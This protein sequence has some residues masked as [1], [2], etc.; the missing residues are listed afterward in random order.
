MPLVY[1]AAAWAAGIAVAQKISFPIH[2]WAWWLIFPLAALILTRFNFRFRLA[3]F[4]LAAFLLGALRYASALPALD[5]HSLA[6]FNDRGARALRG[7]IAD[8]PDIRDT[9]TNLRVAITRARDSSA[10]REIAGVALVQ[11]PRETDARYGDAVE[12]FG[13]PTTP[14]EF[15]D[16]SYKEYLARQGVHSLVRY[17]RVTITAREQG[18]P[19]FAALYAFR[20]RAFVTIRALFPEPAASLLAGILLGLDN[21]IPRDLRDAFSATN[22]AHIVA[23]SGFNIAIIAGILTQLARRAMRPALATLAVIGGLAAYT[24]LVGASASV[25]RAALMGALVVIAAYYNRQ[26][27]A[28]NALAVAALAMTALNPF[29]LFDLGFQLSFLATM[30]LVLYTEPIERGLENVISRI[31]PK[32]DKGQVTRDEG[33]MAGEKEILVTRH[34]S[35]VTL[36][37]DS[38]ITTLAAQITTM[39]LIIFAFHRLSLIGLVTNLLVLPAQPA[40]MIL[41]GLAT[42]VGMIAPPLGQI[43]AWIAWAFLQWTIIV[44][45]ATARVPFASLPVGY[46]DAALVGLYYFA[47]FIA[48]RVDWRALREKI[49]L[50]PA[51]ALGIALVFGIWVFTFASTAPDGK[52]HIYFLDTQGGAAT[53]IRAANGAKILIDGGENPSATLS[54][55]G[56]RMPFWDRTLDLIVLT[57]PDGDH[58]AGLVAVLERYDARQIIEPLAPARPSAAY[59]KWRELIAQKNVPT[60]T[61]QAGMQIEISDWRLEIIESK[62]NVLARVRAGNLAIL[63]ADSA[64]P[65]EQSALAASGESLA[66]TVLVAPRKLEQKFLNA[67]NPQ[68]AIL[69]VGD[70]AR[71]KPAQELLRALSGV[72]I[73]R[74]DERG[75]VEVITDGVSLQIVTT[76]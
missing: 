50:R 45:D 76:R 25:V 34:L 70:N 48:P 60:I 26:S 15:A 71:E 2:L 69:F 47:L 55:L 4:C 13:E 3:L 30:G 8:D 64:T 54:A 52:T 17:A 19:F 59:Q 38:L 21:G 5:E 67:V 61:A 23:I 39:P 57:N 29:T 75:A 9:H 36:F 11:V 53:F 41:G 46:F 42:M 43:I 32:S 44:V 40:V 24:L 6:F 28:Y 73:L 65:P 66:S 58:L 63:F 49:S 16:F 35:L 74:T 33:K 14:P 7:I 1:I 10:W 31:F 56:S 22:T 12:I 51:L 68:I 37:Q 18:N 20:A 62:A 72:T 27:G